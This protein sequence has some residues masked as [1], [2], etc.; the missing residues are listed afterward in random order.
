MDKVVLPERPGQAHVQLLPL[1][2]CSTANFVSKDEEER[3]R[4]RD[5]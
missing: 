3:E 5:K 4:E 1:P 2:T